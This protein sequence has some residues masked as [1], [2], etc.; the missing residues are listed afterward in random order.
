MHLVTDAGVS[1]TATAGIIH[2]ETVTL[3]K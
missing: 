2:I 1:A 3:K